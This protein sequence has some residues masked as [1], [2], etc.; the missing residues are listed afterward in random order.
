MTP[1]IMRLDMLE[2]RRALEGVV[3][4]VQVLHPR[5]QSR[6]AG[7]DGAEVALEVADVDWVEADLRVRV[8]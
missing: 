8:R 1:V 3:V 5:V 6:V 2:V 4:P 7:A